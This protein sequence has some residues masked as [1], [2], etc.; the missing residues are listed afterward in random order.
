MIPWIPCPE[1]CGNYWC[2]IHNEH[3]HDCPCP[4]VE[5]WEQSPYEEQPRFTMP[6]LEYWNSVMADTRTIP[7]DQWR[8]PIEQL[9]GAE[10]SQMRPRMHEPRHYG[11]AE[12]ERDMKT[13]LRLL[14]EQR[15][16]Q[17]PPQKLASDTATP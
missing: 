2:Q 4:P 13:L 12:I 8:G 16:A 17:P 5:E 11:P 1:N 10:P 15:L 3:A 9:T 14:D 6:D 7:R